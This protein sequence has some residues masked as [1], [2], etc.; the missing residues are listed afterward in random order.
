MVLVIHR[1][2]SLEYRN[3]Y[4]G[5]EDRQEVIT[6]RRFIVA[7][8]LVSLVLFPLFG[9]TYLKGC[10]DGIARYKQSKN[11]MLT[12]YSMYLFGVGDG[13]KGGSICEGKK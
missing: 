7:S 11:F 9:Y 1:R 5:V 12:L 6:M 13:C 4:N 2:N 10:Q 3:G 8:L